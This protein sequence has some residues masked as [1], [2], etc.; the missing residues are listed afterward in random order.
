M[1]DGSARGRGSV[2][3]NTCSSESDMTHKL[4]D[5]FCHSIATLTRHGYRDNALFTVRHE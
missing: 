4:I 5:F 2:A 3:G 1:P